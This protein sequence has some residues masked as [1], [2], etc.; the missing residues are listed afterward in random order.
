MLS[1]GATIQ[2]LAKARPLTLPVL[3]VDRKGSSFTYQALQA[4][5]TRIV[6]HAEIAGAGHYIAQEAADKLASAILPFLSET[7]HARG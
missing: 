6:R 2:D 7:D 1:E 4:V 5:H 3:A